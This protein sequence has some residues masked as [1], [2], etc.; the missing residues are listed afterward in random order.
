[1]K[2]LDSQ[3][4]ILLLKKERKRLADLQGSIAGIFNSY[5]TENSKVG[6]YRPGYGVS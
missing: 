4:T 1:M 6:A 3:L 2:V 5:S